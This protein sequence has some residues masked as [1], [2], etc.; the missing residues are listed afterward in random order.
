M[1]PPS[2]LLWTWRLGSASSAGPPVAVACC[3]SRR[4]RR[5]SAW[6]SAWRRSAG[7]WYLRRC[8]RRRR[9]RHGGSSW[10]KRLRR[11][12]IGC[13]VRRMS[14][15]R[16][17]H[18][19]SGSR[20]ASGTSGARPAKAASGTARRGCMGKHRASRRTASRA[21][22][23]MATGGSGL[24]TRLR[25]LSLGGLSLPIGTP[26]R[27]SRTGSTLDAQLDLLDGR[28]PSALSI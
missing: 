20:R 28:R 21:M 24:L 5:R 2:R 17:R 7:P 14:D 3:S 19:R 16:Q 9:R 6:R 22:R 4:R 15:R 11:R 8:R 10:P 1:G 18:R 27:E 23:R 26:D 25:G 13:G 12:G